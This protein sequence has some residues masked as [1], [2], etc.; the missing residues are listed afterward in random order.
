MRG[1]SHVSTKL[2]NMAR[3]CWSALTTTDALTALGL[4]VE[5]ASS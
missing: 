1:G 4:G 5:T 2:A 3:L